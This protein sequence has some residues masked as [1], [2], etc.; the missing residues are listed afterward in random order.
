MQVRKH[1]NGSIQS[2]SKQI[3]K[4]GIRYLSASKFADANALEAVGHNDEVEKHPVCVAIKR[5]I[6]VAK[7]GET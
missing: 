2:L 6:G 5:Y 1:V 3:K 7:T 4:V